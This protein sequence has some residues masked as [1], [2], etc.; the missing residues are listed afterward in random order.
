M[1]S[2]LFCLSQHLTSAN[3]TFLLLSV[4]DFIPDDVRIQRRVSE[5]GVVDILEDVDGLML[6]FL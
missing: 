5:V 4:L 1:L 2:C 3:S 6:L